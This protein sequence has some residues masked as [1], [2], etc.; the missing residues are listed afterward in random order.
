MDESTEAPIRIYNWNYAGAPMFLGF[1]VAPAMVLGFAFFVATGR[2]VGDDGPSDPGMIIMLSVGTLIL[3]GILVYRA[4]TLAVL[5]LE[6]GDRIRYRKPL[7]TVARPWS[8]IK[9]VCL[10]TEAGLR[11][12]ILVTPIFTV[13]KALTVHSVLVIQ[14]RDET[15]VRVKIRQKQLPFVEA[16]RSRHRTSLVTSVEG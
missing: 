14:F 15:D 10:E 11:Q 16:I 12:P 7:W 2:I 13:S 5:W 8:D 9:E 4:C 3:A 6:V 1:I